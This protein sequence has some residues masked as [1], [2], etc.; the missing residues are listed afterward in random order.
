MGK[1]GKSIRKNLDDVG[2]N[3]LMPFGKHK[4]EPIE[5]VPAGYL[6]W[7]RDQEPWLSE[8]FPAVKKYID[9]NEKHI[10]AELASESE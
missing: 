8:N 7:L 6:D 10:D 1:L 2:G 4:G 9:E 3:L 5:A